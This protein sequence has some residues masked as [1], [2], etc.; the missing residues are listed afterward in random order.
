MTLGLHSQRAPLQVLALAMSPRLGLRH[1]N[2]CG[3]I[4]TSRERE[5]YFLTFINDLF[6]K[7]FFY[8]MKT[9]FGVFDKLKVCKTLVKNQTKKKSK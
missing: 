2:L 9:K 1:T 6:K 4:V 3:P 7:S 5:K 8:T